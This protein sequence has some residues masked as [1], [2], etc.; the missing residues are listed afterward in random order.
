MK[1]EANAL[2]SL[3]VANGSSLDLFYDNEFNPKQINGSFSYKD[4]DSIRTI[5]YARIDTT[6]PK[7]RQQPD[8]IKKLYKEDVDYINIIHTFAYK[9]SLTKKKAILTDENRKP[10]P[11]ERKLLDAR[12]KIFNEFDSDTAKYKSYAGTTFSMLPLDYKKFIKIYL[13]TL[14]SK[15]GV[16]VFGN[17]Y[18]FEYDLKTSTLTKKE[19]IHKVYYNISPQYGGKKHDVVKSTF[20]THKDKEGDSPYITITDIC[21]LKLYKG[22]VEWDQHWIYSTKWITTYT[23]FDE[24]IT[25]IDLKTFKKQTKPK[26]KDPYENP[27]KKE[28]GE[29]Q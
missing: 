14:P 25:I 4:K 2:Y 12:F 28:D 29:G 20:H 23:M 3:E 27:E 6:E 21:L 5:F 18:Y 17:D 1:D 16:L 11:Y 13:I 8:S 22:G 26:E 9:G 19:K 10:T 24:K 15:P 7:F